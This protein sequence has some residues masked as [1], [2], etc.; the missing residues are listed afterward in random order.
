ML[1]VSYLWTFCPVLKN[2]KNWKNVSSKFIQIYWPARPDK[3]GLKILTRSKRTWEMCSEI[4]WAK[5]AKAEWEI[6]AADIH[7]TVVRMIID[8]RLT[9]ILSVALLLLSLC[10]V[11]QFLDYGRLKLEIAFAKEQ[12]EIFEEMRLKALRAEPKETVGFL[13]YAIDYYPSGTKQ[14]SGSPLDAIVERERAGNIREIIIYLKSKSNW[15]LGDDPQ[16]W[17]DHFSAGKNSN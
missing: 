1:P 15:D 11:K 10:F 8:K 3:N 4:L 13:R 17:I 12:I 9:I 7:T 14:R 2:K 6:P 5:K 16:K